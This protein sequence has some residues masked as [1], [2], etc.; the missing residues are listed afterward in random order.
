MPKPGAGLGN[1]PPGGLLCVLN[2]LYGRQLPSYSDTQ[3][4][5]SIYSLQDAWSPRE[6]LCAARSLACTITPGEW[7]EFSVHHRKG[8]DSS[9]NEC[10]FERN[11]NQTKVKLYGWL[12]GTASGSDSATSVLVSETGASLTWS[13]LIQCVNSMIQS[14]R[15]G[16]F[17]WHGLYSWSSVLTISV[18]VSERQTLPVIRS[19]LIQCINNTWFRVREKG[20]SSDTVSTVI[21][22]VNMHFSVRDGHFLR[23]GLY[24]NPV[25]TTSD[26]QMLE[27]FCLLETALHHPWYRKPRQEGRVP[28]KTQS[29]RPWFLEEMNL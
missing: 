17:L 18:L 26:L 2:K 8:Q 7:E 25:L 23:Y 20:P 6:M 9:K 1:I 14:Q 13:L 11:Q 12:S 27:R 4:Q 29:Q 22:C 15:E 16:P 10:E 3:M 19:L 24:G 21:E 5:V 28:A